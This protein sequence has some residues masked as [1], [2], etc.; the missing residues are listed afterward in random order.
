MISLKEN[1]FQNSLQFWY[2]EEYFYI[3]DTDFAPQ[4]FCSWWSQC[5]HQEQQDLPLQ[6][7]SLTGIVASLPDVA[8]GHDHCCSSHSLLW[9]C[10]SLIILEI[11]VLLPALQVL[12]FLLTGWWT[13]AGQ[14]WD[15]RFCWRTGLT[16]TARKLCLGRTEA[17]GVC[18]LREKI[19]KKVWGVMEREESFS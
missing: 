8:T 9:D 5:C 11:W 14:G 4:L 17:S 19:Q 6:V 16:Y 15:R 1:H 2:F 13:K 18:C 10:G 12:C 3:C 7:T